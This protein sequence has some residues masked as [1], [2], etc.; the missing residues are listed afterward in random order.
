MQCLSTLAT[1]RDKLSACTQST[2][3]VKVS[4]NAIAN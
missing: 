4:K 2:E 3:K 1:L